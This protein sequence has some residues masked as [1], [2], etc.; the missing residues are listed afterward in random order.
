MKKIANVVGIFLF[1]VFA[2]NDLPLIIPFMGKTQRWV[3]LVF[4]V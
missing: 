1:F 2:Q 4:N 3:L